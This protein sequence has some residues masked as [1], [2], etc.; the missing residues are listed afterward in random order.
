M[1]TVASRKIILDAVD[2]NVRDWQLNVTTSI[3]HVTR[4][5]VA[6]DPPLFQGL[7]ALNLGAD[8]VTAYAGVPAA[9]PEVGIKAAVA[10]LVAK[11]GSSPL[12]AV[13]VVL[14]A[15][16][17]GFTKIRE[18][19]IKK[20]NKL[21]N[22]RYDAM[23]GRMINLAQTSAA[24]YR[25]THVAKSIGDT[26]EPYLKGKRTFA[27]TDAAIAFS[28]RFITHL[29]IIPSDAGKIQGNIR[30]S[31][32]PVLTHLKTVFLVSHHNTSWTSIFTQRKKLKLGPAGARWPTRPSS[33]TFQQ[34]K[35]STNQDENDILT[36]M[37]N[38]EI[39]E[40]RLSFGYPEANGDFIFVRPVKKPSTSTY[41]I[42]KSVPI[43]QA[44]L[45]KADAAA[46]SD[47]K[48][49]GVRGF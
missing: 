44:T 35:H 49:A 28:R 27:D 3:K 1:T 11:G 10:K 6:K 5:L 18:A 40:A 33:S 23:M 7:A 14:G 47:C 39:K 13:F 36:N 42:P 30:K 21:L 2:W 48:Q 32:R 46:V 41:R 34:F 24:T 31:L 19:E 37:S 9:T 29:G 22:V 43:T 16:E 38:Y 12:A 20:E 17:T 8:V 4:P 25:G 26:V 15:V 45:D